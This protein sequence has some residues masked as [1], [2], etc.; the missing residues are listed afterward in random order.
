[1]KKSKHS[2]GPWEVRVLG[3]IISIETEEQG[4]IALVNHLANC[5]SGILS[6]QGRANARLI[7]ASPTMYEALKALVDWDT[8]H[9]GIYSQHNPAVG[10]LVAQA[11]AALAKAEKGN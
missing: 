11:K 6:R 4:G 10:R 9:D 7:A 1:M 3:T 5:N 8:E 2:P